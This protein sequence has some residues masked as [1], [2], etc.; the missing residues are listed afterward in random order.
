MR[1]QIS[2]TQIIGS[3]FTKFFSVITFTGF[4]HVTLNG[5]SMDEWM[6]AHET[7][8]RGNDLLQRQPLL[9]NISSTDMQILL[10]LQQQYL[11]GQMGSSYIT[12]V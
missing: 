11:T 10:F 7:A 2:V 3:R 8:R 1:D 4:L 5:F 9:F 6:V 12:K